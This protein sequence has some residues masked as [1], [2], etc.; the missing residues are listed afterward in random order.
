[1]TA[2]EIAGE[3]GLPSCKA[4]RPVPRPLDVSIATLAL[5]P[6]KASSKG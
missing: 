3:D 6:M 2:S 1:L 5:L 4:L